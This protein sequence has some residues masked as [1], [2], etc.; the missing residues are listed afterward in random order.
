[1]QGVSLVRSFALYALQVDLE[2]GI[3]VVDASSAA[4]LPF[5]VDNVHDVRAAHPPS[6]E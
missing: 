1:M 4:N 6:G 2:D 5:S 3:L